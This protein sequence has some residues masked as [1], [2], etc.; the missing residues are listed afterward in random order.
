[1]KLIK[2]IRRILYK[3]ASLPD[4]ISQ[5]IAEGIKEHLKKWNIHLRNGINF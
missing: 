4:P 1:M 2:L 5:A 3:K